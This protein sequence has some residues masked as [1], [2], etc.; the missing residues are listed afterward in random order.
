M[1][2]FRN[3]SSFGKRQEYQA[4]ADLLKKGYDVY[5]TLVDDQGIDYILRKEIDDKP[6]YLDIQ[7]KARSKESKP[8]HAARWAGMKIPN[9]RNNYLFIFYSEP[10]SSYWIIPSKTL[11]EEIAYQNKS[12]KNK[13]KYT[14]QLAGTEKGKPVIKEKYNKY[15]NKNGF[16]ILMKSFEQIHRKFYST[17]A[18]P[19]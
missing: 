7:I 19:S 4:I 16:T 6:I 12:G 14:I 8:K 10:L 18:G 2:I 15:R 9:P 1:T 3:T 5:Q 13:G 17:H 11:T